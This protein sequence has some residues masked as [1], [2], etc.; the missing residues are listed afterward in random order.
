M[1]PPDLQRLV[2]IRDYCQKIEKSLAR[3]DASFEEFDANDE[4]QQSVA[5][6]VLQIGELSGKLSPE[7]RQATAGI[8]PWKLIRGMRNLVVHDYGHIN[9]RLLWATA[10]T[11]IPPLKKFCEEQLAENK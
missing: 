4:F 5:F 6:C 10:V 7:Y 11:D 9:L 1:L 3:H 8:I 2:H